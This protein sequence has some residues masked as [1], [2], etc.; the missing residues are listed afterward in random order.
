GN[1]E[2]IIPAPEATHAVKGAIDA[3]LECKEKGESKTILFNLCGH[4]HFD[5]SAYDDYFTGKLADDVFEEE[6][7][8][9]AIANLPDVL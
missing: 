9:N 3:A 2:G 1:Q 8:N 7:V 4:G 5:M 6:S